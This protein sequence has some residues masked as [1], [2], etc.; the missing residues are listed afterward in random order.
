ML[1]RHLKTKSKFTWPTTFQL[2]TPNFDTPTLNSLTTV[3]YLLG[4][5]FRLWIPFFGL[6]FDFCLELALETW[7]KVSLTQSLWV[8]DPKHTHSASFQWSGFSDQRVFHLTECCLEVQKRCP[9]KGR[10][11]EWFL[12]LFVLTRWEM[13]Q[14]VPTN[15][16]LQPAKAAAMCTAPHAKKTRPPP[17]IP[18]F[19]LA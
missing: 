9:Y 17:P 1:Y 8:H 4:V 10:G 6:Y 16:F 12:S 14:P 19:L 11:V 13:V 7:A 18:P 3:G 2:L 5:F 15:T